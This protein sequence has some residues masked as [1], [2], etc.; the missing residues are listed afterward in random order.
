VALE[1]KRII[2]RIEETVAEVFAGEPAATTEA[3][4]KAVKKWR[5][6]KVIKASKKRA[7]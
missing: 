5:A 2:E 4:V 6:K 3:P 7:A 1:S